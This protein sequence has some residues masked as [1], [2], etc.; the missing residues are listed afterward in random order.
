MIL[1]F[2]F[3]WFIMILIHQLSKRLKILSVREIIDFKQ[4]KIQKINGQNEI[5]EDYRDGVEWKRNKKERINQSEEKLKKNSDN[6]F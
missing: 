5:I 6:L 4:K 3:S 1:Y 2:P